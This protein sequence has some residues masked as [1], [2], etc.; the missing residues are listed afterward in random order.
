[1]E[2][3]CEGWWSVIGME[4]PPCASVPCIFRALGSFA[5]R[6][7][8]V[9]SDLHGTSASGTLCLHLFSQFSGPLSESGTPESILITVG[10]IQ[11]DSPG[12]RHRKRAGLVQQLTL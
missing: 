2:L 12:A 3:G 9:G 8:R 4:V 5:A 1:M 10:L 11:N 6:L 7:F